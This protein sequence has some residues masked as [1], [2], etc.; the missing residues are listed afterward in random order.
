LII[1]SRQYGKISK[2]EVLNQ[3]LIKIRFSDNEIKRGKMIGKTNEVVFLLSG[4][5]VEVIPITSLVKE[6]QIMQ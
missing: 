2:A 4:E 6:I 5:N 3:P 1:A